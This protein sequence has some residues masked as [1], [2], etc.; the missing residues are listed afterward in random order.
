MEND[1]NCS[2]DTILTKSDAK[3]LSPH[4]NDSYLSQESQHLTQE[5]HDSAIDD[6]SV[7]NYTISSVSSGGQ[8]TCQD[9]PALNRAGSHPSMPINYL[10]IELT[11]DFQTTSSSPYLSYVTLTAYVGHEWVIAMKYR[12]E[13]HRA[14]EILVQELRHYTK[15]NKTDNY[16]LWDNAIKRIKCNGF[17]SHPMSRHKDR[18]NSE[19]TLQY[20]AF[21]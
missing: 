18:L 8:S 12:C 9:I 14:V 15:D 10:N 7:T 6:E 13:E 21:I 20:N 1:G 19:P 11:D 16:K 4:F 5:L 17:M 3:L 2:V